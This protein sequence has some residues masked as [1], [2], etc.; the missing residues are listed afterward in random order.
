MRDGA[1]IVRVLWSLIVSVIMGFVCALTAWSAL[2]SETQPV[3]RKRRQKPVVAELDSMRILEHSCNQER[4]AGD[5][6]CDNLDC[7]APLE[8]PYTLAYVELQGQGLATRLE[9]YLL[10]CDCIARASSGAVRFDVVAAE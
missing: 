5:Y 8:V 6:Q 3:T 2:P 4:E 9:T 1:G 10:C 7:C